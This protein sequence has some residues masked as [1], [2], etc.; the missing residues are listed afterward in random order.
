M[1]SAHAVHPPAPLPGTLEHLQRLSSSVAGPG[2]TV[3]C[4]PAERDL[5][6]TLGCLE[7]KQQ[8]GLTR[9]SRDGKT[10]HLAAQA[11]TG[12]AGHSGDREPQR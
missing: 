5:S 8:L 10:V 7:S 11:Q 12:R 3:P 2:A 9:T 1:H 4:S 6:E